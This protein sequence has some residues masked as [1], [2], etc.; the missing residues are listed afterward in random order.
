MHSYKDQMV[1]VIQDD[2]FLSIKN[3]LIDTS[4]LRKYIFSN[5]SNINVI[6]RT[7]NTSFGI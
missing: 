3:M 4:V 5:Q 6:Q 7:H 2:I 1:A